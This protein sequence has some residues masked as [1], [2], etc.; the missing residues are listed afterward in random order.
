MVVKGERLVSTF[1]LGACVVL[2]CFSLACFARAWFSWQ[3]WYYF[4]S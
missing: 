3:S 4:A 1:S 2:S